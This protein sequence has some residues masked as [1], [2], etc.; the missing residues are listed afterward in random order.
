MVGGTSGDVGTSAR[1]AS[2]AAPVT[3]GGSTARKET[4]S[5]MPPGDYYVVALDDIDGE[6]TRDPDLLQQLAR[7]ATRVSVNDTTP[8]DVSLR[9][10]KL[11]EIVR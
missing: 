3:P 8:A 4:I 9:R 2:G 10:L 6:S 11:S 5:A 7:S 1:P